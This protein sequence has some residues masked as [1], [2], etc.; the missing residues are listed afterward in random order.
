MNDYAS[1]R[2]PKKASRSIAMIMAV[3]LIIEMCSIAVLFSRVVTYS[4]E[5]SKYV[6]SLTEGGNLSKNA[7]LDRAASGFI[8]PTS[9][10]DPD[11]LIE[12]IDKVNELDFGFSTSDD[13]Q[14]WTTD[15]DIEVF[16]L[17]YSETGELTVRS[18]MTGT[19]KVFAPGTGDSFA[20]T[21]KNTGSHDLDYLVY[22]EAGIEAK[23][24]DGNDLWI[25]LEGRFRRGDGTYFVGDP[26]NYADYL[27]LHKSGD[28]SSL[29]AGT[30]TDYFIDW[31]WPYER[32]D[33][34]G[35][36]AN[37][38]YD[39]M[40]GNLAAS[41]T[42]LK[43]TILIK[44]VAW[45]EDYWH[46]YVDVKSGEGTVDNIPEKVVQES[47][48]T[49][50]FTAEPAEGYEFIG[51]EIDDGDVYEITS[52][53]LTSP[54]LV[55]KPGSDVHAHAVF[56]PIA[57]E[58]SVEYWFATADVKSGEGSATVDPAKVVR[59][60]DDTFTFVAT[61]ED[62]YEFVG[63]EFDEG[64]VYDIVSGDLS[65]VTLIVKP[66]SD[67]HAHAVFKPET[68][69][70]APTEPVATEEPPV[71]TQ[72]GPTENP[73]VPT[74]PVPTEE[75]PVPTQPVPTEIPTEP[76]EPAPT[77][78]PT[79]PHVQP[80]EKPTV[81]V[82]YWNATADVIEGEGSAKVVPN[83]VVQGSSDTFEFSA[84]PAEG[85]EF[86]RWE[87]DNGDV[88]EVVSGSVDT[89][90]IVVK[91]GSDVHAHA[92]FKPV[93]PYPANYSAVAQVESGEGTATVN[94]D[95]VVAGSGDTFTFEA[96]P[97]DGYE[98]A[99][100]EFEGSYT[101]IEGDVNS[102]KVVL[103]PGSDIVGKAKFVPKATEGP[104]VQPSVAP[105]SVPVQPR[106][107]D[108]TNTLLWLIISIAA[109][110]ALIVLFFVYRRTKKAEKAGGH[111]IND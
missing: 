47:G 25:P 4:T 109:F 13:E 48:D 15:T 78:E 103:M 2:K 104:T 98:F 57:T 37:D 39:T 110:V 61:P 96:V 64:D 72:P 77:Q 49:F 35:L 44:T 70:T 84:I 97:A 41:G 79:E 93:E 21:V 40:L 108:T 75:P 92:V 85:Y 30:K 3:L 94:P 20:F 6:I 69:P 38:A 80:T 101:I 16:H 87:F 54:T 26:D 19:P 68:V 52:G 17:T 66:G 14:I 71:P 32:F 102:L 60:S 43:A 50:T 33:G 89:M 82:E 56:A 45:W 83:K 81:P 107:G 10:V 62:G 90:T 31:Q 106:T 59:G 27:A 5:P 7:S 42:E 8:V 105:T 34:D 22:L 36:E 12:A 99:G 46:S 111:N 55:V 73:P 74:E 91:P 11:T 53:S 65:S 76:T 67:L 24:E 18:D 100:W 95:T 29:N 63:W 51:W 86:V 58:P 88:Y 9:V 28:L 23:D 1:L